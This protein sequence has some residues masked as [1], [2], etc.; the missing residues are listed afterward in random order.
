MKVSTAVALLLG[1]IGVA[2]GFT[3]LIN[4][5]SNAARGAFQTGTNLGLG[6]YST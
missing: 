4:A 1:L 2:N 5:G 6:K 3:D